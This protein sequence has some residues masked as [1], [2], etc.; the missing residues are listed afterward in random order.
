MSLAAGDYIWIC[1]SDDFAEPTFLEKA[2]NALEKDK[3]AVL[4]Y[5][6]SWVVDKFG[7]QIDHTNTYFHEIWKS[8]RWDADFSTDGLDE[9]ANFQIRGQTV[10]I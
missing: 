10:P 1:E 2:V 6:N 3:N 5:C 4:F 9:L 8:K 7:N